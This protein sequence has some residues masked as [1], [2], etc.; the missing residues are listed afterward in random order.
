MKTIR[1]LRDERGWSQF[2]LAVKI[3]VTP[4]AISAW[5]RGAYE[6][7]AGQLR[8]MAQ[9]FSVSMDD[10]AFESPAEGKDAA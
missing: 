4:T 10:I 7:R 9:A 8:K 1:E 3:G 6:P 5:E 2:E